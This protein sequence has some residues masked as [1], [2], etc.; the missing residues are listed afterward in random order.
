MTTRITLA[1]L[2]TTWVILIVGQTA[3]FLTAR[4]RLLALLDDTIIT[5]AAGLAEQSAGSSRD[6]DAPV[7]V[8]LGDRFEIRD[9]KSAIVDGGVGT[10]VQPRKSLL[11]AE[12]QTDANGK[13]FRTVTVRVSVDRD[14]RQVPYVVSYSRAAEPF[15][16]LQSHLAWT[17]LLISLSCGL[18]TAW[19]SLKLSRAALRPLHRTADEIAEIDEQNLGRRIDVNAMPIELVPMTRR[20]NEMLER[21]QNVFQQ[22]KQFLA[23]AAHELRTP[24]AALLTTLEVAL[25]RPR[26]QAALMETMKSG[27]ADAR[28]LR[29]LVEQLMEHARS[30]HLRGPES[31][32]EA[33]VPAMLRECVQIVTPLAREKDISITEELPAE[34]PFVTQRERMR[35]IVLNLLSNAI[36]YNR[37]GGSVRLAAERENGVLRLT[38]ADT[39]QG[40]TPEQLPQ[41]FEPFYRGGNGRGDDPEH[42]GLGLFLVRS[43]VDALHGK[44]E[45]DSK[46]GV[47]TTLKITLPEPKK[48]A[49]IADGAA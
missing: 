36:E 45:I 34:L 16:Q 42:L 22:R 24:T 47:G 38:I 35:S 26:D 4:S 5:R 20:L 49:A 44:C 39:G 10:T 41:V 12:F 13:R 9:A 28:R 23:D 46:V 11:Q 2:L 43:H 37:H 1:I 18:A 25:R 29:K 6:P 40:I 31:M 27:L 33:D 15:D 14:G 32:Q 8:P 19:L 48:T 17:L 3:A 7:N 30:E 21:L